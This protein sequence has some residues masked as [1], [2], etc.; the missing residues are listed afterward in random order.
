MFDSNEKPKSPDQA[1]GRILEKAVA[2][3]DEAMISDLAHIAKCISWLMDRLK[4][5]NVLANTELD[6]PAN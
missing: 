4:Q 2:A 3:G 6:G 1:I 5:A